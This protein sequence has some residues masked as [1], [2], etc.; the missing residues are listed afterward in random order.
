MENLEE[1]HARGRDRAQRK[2]VSLRRSQTQSDIMTWSLLGVNVKPIDFAHVESTLLR[3]WDG[4]GVIECRDIG[5]FR[6]LITFE[7]EKIRDEAMENQ[8]LLSMFDEV[9]HHW[10]TVWSLS[11][12]I[13]IEVDDKEY[14]IFAKEFDGEV[15]SRESHPNE[16]EMAYMGLGTED[17]RTESKVEETPNQTEKMI[18][19]TAEVCD[20]NLNF[21]NVASV[22]VIEDSA[23]ELN[24]V[25]DE[26]MEVVM[27]T[28]HAIDGGCGRQNVEDD[29]EYIENV[30]ANR[31][32]DMGREDNEADEVVDDG[33]IGSPRR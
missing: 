30:D 16:P 29:Y 3:E 6:C 9:R 27:E 24:D 7:S 18:P 15:Y 12:R 19:V 17:T 23:R 8:A 20:E 1:R 32:V 14:E 11:R 25:I 4:R 26:N 21:Q 28:M 22:P 10:G 13:W 31:V 2:V 33:L 5:P